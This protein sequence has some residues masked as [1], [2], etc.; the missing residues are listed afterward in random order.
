MNNADLA[1]L[2]IDATDAHTQLPQ[3]VRRLHLLHTHLWHHPT[4]GD[5]A[6][7]ASGHT[8]PT[9]DTVAASIDARRHLDRALKL[10]LDACAALR[11]AWTALDQAEGSTAGYDGTQAA[12]DAAGHRARCTNCQQ[13]APTRRG[14]CQPCNMWQRRHGTARPPDQWQRRHHGGAA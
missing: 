9:G 5:I 2:D 1:R 14:L 6:I 3:L 11:G 7:I 4:S 10:A 12:A 13:H 8:D